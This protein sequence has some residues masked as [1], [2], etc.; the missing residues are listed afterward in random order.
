M[1][2]PIDRNNEDLLRRDPNPELLSVVV[3]CFNEEEVLLQN[4]C[5]L[6]GALAQ[7]SDLSFEI[8]YVDDESGTPRRIFSG[9]CDTLTTECT[10]WRLSRNFGHQVAIRAGL[11]HAWPSRGPTKSGPLTYIP[12]HA[13]SS[14]IG[15]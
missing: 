10:R 6:V 7:I 11:E 9:I 14:R 13:G 1:K 5:R 15:S 4:H 2:K 8:L 3:S 12:W